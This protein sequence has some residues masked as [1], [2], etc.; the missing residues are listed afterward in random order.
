MSHLAGRLYRD[1]SVFPHPLGP[2]Y[3]SKFLNVI[4]ARCD[5]IFIQV[6]VTVRVFV[7]EGC[8]LYLPAISLHEYVILMTGQSIELPCRAYQVPILKC[9]HGLGIIF[10]F[11][12]NKM[13][14]HELYFSVPVYRNFRNIMSV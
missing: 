12:F 3:K 11:H 1:F 14:F 8:N 10:I 9:K 4:F 7:R 6:Y 13:Q 5:F 2:C